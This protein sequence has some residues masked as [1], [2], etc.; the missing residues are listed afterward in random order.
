MFVL[1]WEITASRG[2]SVTTPLL[3]VKYKINIFKQH[4]DVLARL[5]QKKNAVK[6]PVLTAS[7]RIRVTKRP[8]VT[9]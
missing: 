2:M 7:D 8:E 3:V 6:R 5:E 9:G 4:L 1:H